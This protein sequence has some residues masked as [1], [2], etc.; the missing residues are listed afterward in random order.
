MDPC[1]PAIYLVLSDVQPV[2]LSFS[3]SV[4]YLAELRRDDPHGNM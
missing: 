3:L 2:L 4:L 1:F